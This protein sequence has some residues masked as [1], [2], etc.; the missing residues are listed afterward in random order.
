MEWEKWPYW[1]KGGIIS[2]GYIVIAYILAFLVSLVFKSIGTPIYRFVTFFDFLSMLFCKGVCRGWEGLIQIYTIWFSYIIIGFFLGWV[3][4]KIKSKRILIFVVLIILTLVG[5]LLF[6][7]Y[8]NSTDYLIENMSRG[9]NIKN[10]KVYAYEPRGSESGEYSIVEVKEA[11]ANSFENLICD[12][13]LDKSNVYWFHPRDYILYIKFYNADPKHFQVLNCLYTKD[14]NNVYVFGE[15]LE[16]VDVESF[17]ILDN[18]GAF[19]ARD[20]NYYYKSGRI[21]EVRL[22]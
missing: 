1:L 12:Y 13:A 11:N 20:K 16:G 6:F 15:V 22:Y 18:R 19:D 8:F 5:S 9:F 10:D 3:Y 4:G 2:L 21:E 7:K 17:T 14:K